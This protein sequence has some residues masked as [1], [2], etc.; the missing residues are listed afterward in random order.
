MS[1]PDNRAVLRKHLLRLDQHIEHLQTFNSRFSWLRL[2]ILV[3]GA[4]AIWISYSRLGAAG[5]RLSI[6]GMVVTFIAV[7]FFHRRLDH[8]IHVF[9]IWRNMQSR[10]LARLE[11]DWT[12]LPNPPLSPDRPRLTL[13]VDL[14]LTG[15]RSLHQLLDL[16]ISREGSHLLADW[17]VQSNPDTEQILSRQALVRELV[18]LRRFRERLL[19]SFHR[20]SREAM[21]GRKLLGWLQ[22]ELPVGR[23]SW[24]LLLSTAWVSLN[25][26]LFWLNSLGRIPAY[27]LL[28]LVL[29]AIFYFY[30][31]PAI[32]KFLES[33]VELDNELDKFRPLVH[34][35]ETRSLVGCPHLV[36]LLAPFND[37]FHRPSV[38]LRQIKLVTAMVGLRMNPMIGLLLNAVLPWDFLG[39]FLAA[40]CR[41]SVVQ[42]L[43]AWL[44]V[45]YEL[46]AL[47]SLAN[48]AF[49]NPDCTFPLL[50]PD[51]QP[52]F[53]AE[54]IGHPLIPANQRVGNNFSIPDL[55]QVTIITGSNMAGKSTFIKTVGINIC[56]A[57]S[58][59]PV[60]A[61]NMRI[62]P[63][64][65]HT[66][67]HIADSVADG[68]SYFYMEV[69]CLKQLLE[70]LKAENQPPVLF[71]I[72]EIFR[73]TNNR[74]R[75]IGSRAYIHSVAGAHGVGLLATHDL[76]LA[77]LATTNPQVVNYH[78]SDQ[79]L[80]N[81]LTFDYKIHPGPSTTT[82]AI[83]IMAMEGLPLEIPPEN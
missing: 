3:S 5:G 36:R 61:T 74:E 49:L 26:L 30:S 54:D 31:Q 82:N 22:E 10:Q 39:A 56:L 40:R 51:A 79:V 53:R 13:D 32:N 41:S 33:I 25:I 14:D 6:G 1:S 48:Y 64:R 37:P 23:L 65:L 55:G 68:F 21:E 43:P 83:Q 34:Y 11:L 12:G 63:F 7:V 72:D 81:K 76:E 28:S 8:W 73:G 80:A 62:V 50:V 66:C 27:W 70:E 47:V 16:S 75:M 59:G 35:L 42:T 67:I 58:G 45:M 78:F 38:Q 69:R 57:Y 19:F 46:E 17:L 4:L 18:P 15:P 24:T 60:I 44:R 20:L 77:E 29:Y 2:G 52:V 9:Q 71:L